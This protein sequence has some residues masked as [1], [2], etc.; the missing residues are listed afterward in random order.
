MEKENVHA[1]GIGIFTSFVR[2][3]GI[4]VLIFGL[5]I[6]YQV[7][8]E[9][10]QLYRSP[11]KI[12]KY[13]EKVEQGS[14]MDKFGESLCKMSHEMMTETV[15]RMPQMQDSK[16]EKELTPLVPFRLSYFAAWGIIVLLLLVIGKIACWIIFT[17]GKLALYSG[18]TEK[19]AQAM[20]RQIMLEMGVRKQD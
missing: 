6:G 11:E 4:G 19:L 9:S 12:E 17:G 15:K 5:W 16:Q 13:A 8:S 2:I 1:E 3:V 20:V 18:N 7:V 10:W 14:K